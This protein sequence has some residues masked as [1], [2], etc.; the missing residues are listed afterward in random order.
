MTF[1]IDGYVP[2][3]PSIALNEGTTFDYATPY[4]NI[5]I[6]ARIASKDN[7]PF[8][9]AYRKIN[10]QHQREDSLGETNVEKQ[11]ADL[12]G[13][14]FDTVVM[15]WSTTVKSG[16]KDIAPSREN[17][18]NLLTSDALAYVLVEFMGDVSKVAN[19]RAKAEEDAEKN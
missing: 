7:L 11:N 4:G 6:V 12:A 18:V 5:T 2:A 10:K 8:A 14:Y 9:R 15:R 3:D 16:G 1:Q 13:C 19:F 17:F